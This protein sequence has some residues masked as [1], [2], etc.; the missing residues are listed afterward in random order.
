MLAVF[1]L[2]VS[3]EASQNNLDDQ[4]VSTVPLNA[5]TSST[6]LQKEQCSPEELEQ[7]V[8]RHLYPEFSP[9][10]QEKIEI[11]YPFF[12][13]LF[14]DNNPLDA[15]C[16]GT[17]HTLPVGFLPAHVKKIIE[18]LYKN[19]KTIAV[20]ETAGGC[21]EFFDEEHISSLDALR[22]RKKDH[23]SMVL[24]VELELE[25]EKVYHIK[26]FRPIYVKTETESELKNWNIK[27][28]RHLQEYR[29]F[30]EKG[31]TRDQRF[32]TLLNLFRKEEPEN[33]E[34]LIEELDSL[35]LSAFY[36]FILSASFDYSEVADHMD[37]G[38]D[39]LMI[40]IFSKQHKLLALDSDSTRKDAQALEI[41]QKLQQRNCN[42]NV[43]WATL[44]S[45]FQRITDIFLTHTV[46]E[47]NSLPLLDNMPRTDLGGLLTP[48]L[49]RH[50][51]GI[52][53]TDPTQ[54]SLSV[55]ERNKAW[56]PTILNIL[57]GNDPSFFFFGAGHLHGEYGIINLLRQKGYEL[58]RMNHDGTFSM[59]DESLYLSNAKESEE[60]HR[61]L[62]TTFGN[63]PS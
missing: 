7:K 54:E 47:T 40:D 19:P 9:E 18:K 32:E 15:Y 24:N 5:S 10:T 28:T 4:A 45:E 1:A 37:F 30:L 41:E 14:K 17:F 31:W 8:Q 58:R 26:F 16:L 35:S 20:S 25:N 2:S 13:Q 39:T 50:L 51:K 3:A 49:E 43:S 61:P 63:S 12:Y 27:L 21:E 33:G 38:M 6:S 59:E 62:Q 52:Y 56:E 60:Y 44:M 36:E 53:N 23:P 42:S 46:D 29:D 34:K 22:R 11:Y 48:H 57:Q 55:Q